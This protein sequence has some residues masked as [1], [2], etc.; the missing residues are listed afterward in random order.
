M[1]A[2]EGR[3]VQ[4]VETSFFFQDKNYPKIQII[5]KRELNY[6]NAL[7]WPSGF[8]NLHVKMIYKHSSY[9]SYCSLKCFVVYVSLNKSKMLLSW[10]RNQNM[11]R[12]FDSWIN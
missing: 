8:Q 11:E 6:P 2:T 4:K 3:I 5:A 1:I 9:L 12:L 10:K 7:F